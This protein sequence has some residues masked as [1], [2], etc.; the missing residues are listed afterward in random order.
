MKYTVFFLATLILTML[1]LPMGVMAQ[2]E[3]QV[4]E[5]THEGCEM[6]GDCPYMVDGECTYEG[7]CPYGCMGEGEMPMGQECPGM[8]G[9]PMEQP[10]HGGMPGDIWRHMDDS[11][12]NHEA[13]MYMGNVKTILI[14]PFAD[15]TTPTYEGDAVL[16]EVG[17]PMR[18]VDNLAG[19]F[20]NRGYLV[21]PPRDAEAAYN[22]LLSPNR[23]WMFE[24]A[25]NMAPE[26]ENN[27]FYFSQMPERSMEFYE[28]VVP[29]LDD[30]A[31]RVS[32]DGSRFL[33]PE[34][35][36]NLA[37]IFNAD[38]VV[39]GFVNEYAIAKDI[40]ADWRTL[41]PPFLGL[42]N[43]DKRITMEVS[44][45][46]YDGQTGQL[47][48]NDTVEMQRNSDWPIFNSDDE[49]LRGVEHDVVAS[50][51][52]SMLPNWQDMVWEH[53]EW[54]PFEMWEGMGPG[55]MGMYAPDWVNPNR[56]GWHE[57]YLDKDWVFDPGNPEM[58]PP[59][60]RDRDFSHSYNA[61]RQYLESQD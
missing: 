3:A 43:P 9:M 56:D 59:W 6:A 44:Y 21:I 10:W 41:I 58:L 48:W 49:L 51:A 4:G 11:A 45:Y 28:S 5:G 15:Y 35:I 22:N 12:L 33:K 34:D 42:F 7:E 50:A 23:R 16:D 40:D 60:L 46:L 26:T 13:M 2:E 32:T 37:G 53:P 30:Q 14:L 31:S 18:L 47:L 54:V 57:E 29:G 24:D 36:V 19:A 20:M 61:Y 25:D 38:A 17:G 39:R 27:S 8:E 55:E 1:A 52:N